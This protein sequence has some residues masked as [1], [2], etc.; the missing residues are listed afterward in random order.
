M[1]GA[2]GLTLMPPNLASRASSKDLAA[3]ACFVFG[4]DKSYG[5]FMSVGC[6]TALAVFTDMPPVWRR[7]VN[8]NIYAMSVSILPCV[9]SQR[10]VC[11]MLQSVQ[12]L[13]SKHIASAEMTS[14]C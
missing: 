7:P 6:L 5:L 12:C 3:L 8:A 4:T 13:A 1:Q 10:E 11:S 2:V 9:G 14:A